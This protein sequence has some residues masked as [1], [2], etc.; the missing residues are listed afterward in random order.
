MAIETALK[1]FAAVAGNPGGQL[2]KFK[3]E[4]KKV[5]ACMPYYV[6]EE[7][8]FAAGMVPV[9]L[10]GSNKKT[11]TRAKE[12]CASFYCSLVQLAVEMALDGTLDEVDGVITPTMCDTLRPNSQNLKT[13]LGEKAIFL[14]HPQNRF[15]EYGIE[16][17]ME[18]YGEVKEKLEKIA[19]K[20]IENDAILDAVKIYN[21]CR[22][23]KRVFVKLAGSHPA[24]VSAVAR[25][26][27]LKASYFSDKAEY[28]EKLEALNEE[29]RALP[30]SDS[31]YIKVIT[32]G[33][34]CDNPQLLKIFD[35]NKLVIVADDVAHESRSFRMD[36]PEDEKD[37]MRALAV[38]FANQKED[39]V[40]YD[41]TPH[42][43]VRSRHLIRMVKK[44]GA[45]GL[46]MF[47]TQFCD[48]EETDY[49]Y[50]KRDFD[51]AQIPLIH[52][53]I[54]MQMRDFGQ[55]STSLQ[56]FASMIE[57]EDA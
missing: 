33:I 51:T 37:G 9:G 28:T 17:C 35:E 15:K 4:G 11:I 56:A 54:D 45:E 26:A 55:V 57:E 12:Y 42:Q 30:A 46:I 50:I 16:F 24:E 41:N 2:K 19:G 18:N 14:A 21:R 25:G 6:P 10:W 29:L 31:G 3:A 40:L 22:A 53:V 13:I 7:L 39:S 8:V 47:V 1:E 32:S 20:R 27:V 36:A 34:I 52:L 49:P 23:A 5:I 44:T 48:P 43:H 38:Q